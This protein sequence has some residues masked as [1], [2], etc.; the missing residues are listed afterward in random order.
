MKS[1]NEDLEKARV[2]FSHN[3]HT[4]QQKA[5]R[6]ELLTKNSSHHSNPALT[7]VTYQNS[8]PRLPGMPQSTTQPPPQRTTFLLSRNS[9]NTIF[10]CTVKKTTIN[11][12]AP[13]KV[14]RERPLQQRDI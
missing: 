2:S 11:N 10:G 6:E 5:A 4:A 9:G 3:A 12:E 7:T 1:M 14:L 8:T 13:L